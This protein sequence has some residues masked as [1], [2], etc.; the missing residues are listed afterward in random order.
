MRDGVAERSRK[1]VE[2]VSARGGVAE[3]R[4]KARDILAKRRD[5]FEKHVAQERPNAGSRTRPGSLNRRARV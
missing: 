3:G 2:A 5:A 1:A 4:D